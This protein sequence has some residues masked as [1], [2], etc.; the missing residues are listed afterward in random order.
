MT[1]QEQK[2]ELTPLEKYKSS[3]NR[4]Q[5]TFS[6]DWSN[7]WRHE[8]INK[9]FN[10]GSKKPLDFD[11]LWSCHEI[12]LHKK[13]CPN[14]NNDM[15]RENLKEEVGMRRNSFINVIFKQV[16]FDYYMHNI[17]QMIALLSQIFIPIWTK[18]LILWLQDDKAAMG[19]GYYFTGLIV[20]VS[21]LN[22]FL[23]S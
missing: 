5:C 12:F 4:S 6:K 7:I 19:P 14:F 21:F 16:R 18:K 11:D 17:C 15:D 3:K 8:G 22:P 23:N 2:L 13:N 10:L 1:E 9:V 20:F